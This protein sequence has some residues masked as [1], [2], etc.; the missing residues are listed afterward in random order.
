MSDEIRLSIVVGCRNDNHGGALIARLQHFIDNLADQTAGRRDIELVLVEWNPP[1]NQPRLKDVL[2][3]SGIRGGLQVQIVDVPESQHRAFPFSDKLPFFQY[4]AKNVGIRRARGK[5]ILS[6][7]IDI[8]LSQELFEFISGNQLSDRSLYRADRIDVRSEVPEKGSS[9]A[10]LDFCWKNTLRAFRPW[11]LVEGDLHW[12]SPETVN[13]EKVQLVDFQRFSAKNVPLIARSFCFEFLKNVRSIIRFASAPGFW[14]R[15]HSWAEL[16]LYWQCSSAI[17]QS[18]FAFRAYPKVHSGASG[19]FILA[20]RAV[21]EAF[22]GHSETP[23]HPMYL[24]GLTLYQCFYFGFPLV[25]IPSAKPAFHIEHEGGWTPQTSL[26]YFRR[27][28]EQGI[29]FLA[30]STYARYAEQLYQ[31]REPGSFLKKN[32]NWGLGNLELRTFWIGR[33]ESSDF[34]SIAGSPLANTERRGKDVSKID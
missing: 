13:S 27:L 18:L 7:N 24:D 30:K 32:P 9:K 28:K 29:P 17:D 11:G 1:V 23:I 4:L 10:K 5:F 3:W 2:D 19:D 15:R 8:L 12:E 20:S 21:W 34:L 26:S 25:C 14:G 22:G 31:K 33:G 16:S 6:T